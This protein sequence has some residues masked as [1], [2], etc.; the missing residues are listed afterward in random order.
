MGLGHVDKAL[1]VQVLHSSNGMLPRP[2]RRDTVSSKEWLWYYHVTPTLL[3]FFLLVLLHEYCYLGWFP[4]PCPYRFAEA[5]SADVSF[6]EFANARRIPMLL[7][8]ENR[9][10]ASA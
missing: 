1:T 2:W 9:V 6:C 7:R 10:S 5:P 4:R 3:V 8:L